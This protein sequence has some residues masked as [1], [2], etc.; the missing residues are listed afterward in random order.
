MKKLVALTLAA[1]TLVGCGS[2]E[3]A[4]NASPEASAP[5]E[6]VIR[7]GVYEP[8]TGANAASGEL[9]LEGFKIANELYPEVLGKK[10]ELVIFI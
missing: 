3:A 2:Q 8:L 7:I 10:V 5:A 6:D 1:S 9:E 4:P